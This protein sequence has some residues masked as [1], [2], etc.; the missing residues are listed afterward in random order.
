MVLPGIGGSYWTTFFPGIFVMG[1]GMA[2]AVA[3]LVTVVMGSVEPHRAGMASGVNNAISRAAGLVGIAALGVLLLTSFNSRLDEHLEAIGVPDSVVAQLDS[4]RVRL[5][6]AEPPEGIPA[7]MALAIETAIDE[8][9][10]FGF[11]VVMGLA[12]LSALIGSLAALA[13]IEGRRS[14]SPVL[15]VS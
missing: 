5:A 14:E 8:S 12:S 9:F 3:P 13:F 6:S 15:E 10:L 4:E 7:E 1:L 11:P 2:I